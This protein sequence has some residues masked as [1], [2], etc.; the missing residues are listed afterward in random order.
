[1]RSSLALFRLL[2]AALLA[3][4]ENIIARVRNGPLLPSWSFGFE[5]AVRFLKRDLLAAERWSAARFRAELAVRPYP[6]RATAKVTI[7]ERTCGG[8]RALVFVPPHVERRGTLLYFHGGEYRYGSPKT[9]HA[10]FI[11]GL[12]LV[13]GARVVAP[14][15]RL[16]PEQPF[17]AALDDALASSTLSTRSV[18]TEKRSW[19]RGTRR[20]PGSRC[21]SNSHGAIAGSHRLTLR[22]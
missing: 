18:R 12:A 20:V 6:K 10:E 19:S 8:V 22:S 3:L 15:Y 11:A 2:G 16:A 9:T 7:S 4:V 21:Y 17:P 1:V 5:W 13:T 14:E